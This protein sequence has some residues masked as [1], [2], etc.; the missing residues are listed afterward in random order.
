M[1]RLGILFFLVITLGCGSAWAAISGTTN[2]NQGPDYV[3]WGQ[4][5][6]PP[7]YT[8]INTPQMWTSQDGA[9]GTVGL[10]VLNPFYVLQEGV[11]WSGQFANGEYLVYNGRLFG[12]PDSDIF[13]TF[14]KPVYGAG[15][16]VQSDYY[17]PFSATVSAYGSMDNLLYSFTASGY[18]AYG[19]GSA[20]FIGIVDTNREIYSMTFGVVDQFGY[21]DIAMG[22][23]R[24]VP[25]PSTLLLL[26]SGLLGLVGLRWRRK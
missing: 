13:A 23:M 12:N 10:S 3:T 8:P 2:Q 11:T 18:S 4:L 7:D 22:T 25:E 6:V 20:L 17:G 1:R 16:Y 19:P 5:Y 21:N 24:L 9:T 26:G 15:A 14:D